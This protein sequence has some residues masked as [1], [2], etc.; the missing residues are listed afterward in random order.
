MTFLSSVR[1]EERDVRDIAHSVTGSMLEVWALSV[2]RGLP[3]SGRDHPP[4]CAR[5][6]IDGAFTGAVCLRCTRA[7]AERAATAMY[8][9][10]FG[11]RD[12]ATRDAVAE[13]TNMIAGNI[14]SLVSAQI[15]TTCGLSL[16]VVTLGEAILTGATLI[17][18]C[19]FHWYGEPVRIQVEALTHLPGVARA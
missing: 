3:V 15:G 14:K 10:E 12:E 18:E 16:P 1:I 13:L 2:P 19:F 9:E 17:Q 11:D 4:Y 5:V 6:F 7:F 8:G